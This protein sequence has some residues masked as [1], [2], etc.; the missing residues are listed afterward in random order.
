VFNYPIL[1]DFQKQIKVLEEDHQKIG[2]VKQL[3]VQNKLYWTG[4]ESMRKNYFN[5][6]RLYTW[7]TPKKIEPLKDSEMMQLMESE[8]PYYLYHW[9]V[10]MLDRA[11][12]EFE[13]YEEEEDNDEIYRK[14]HS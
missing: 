5:K 8:T 3:L 2:I 9:F 13:E 4:F 11:K 6:L 12:K 7:K 10:D 14:K 1:K